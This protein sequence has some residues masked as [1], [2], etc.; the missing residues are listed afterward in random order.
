LEQWRRIQSKTAWAIYDFL[1]T[2]TS[3]P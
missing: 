1:D 2:E 3:D